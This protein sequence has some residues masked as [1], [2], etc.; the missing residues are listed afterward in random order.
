MWNRKYGYRKLETNKKNRRTNYFTKV[1]LPESTQLG[2]TE[3]KAPLTSSGDPYKDP[4]PHKNEAM[5]Q[6][7]EEIE[8]MIN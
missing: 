7:S 3:D 1:L 4:I 6:A 2:E 5:V 8:R